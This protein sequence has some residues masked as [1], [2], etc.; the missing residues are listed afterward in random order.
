MN[1]INWENVQKFYDDSKDL[2]ATQK[3]FGI[4]TELIHNARKNGKLNITFQLEDQKKEKL[5]EM[6][7]EGLEISKIALKLGIYKFDVIQEC[8]KFNEKEIKL[9][10]K[11]LLEKT[12]VDWDFAQWLYDHNWR[13]EWISEELHIPVSQIETAGE[14]NIFKIT[15]NRIYKHSQF[16]K[17]KIA[18]ARK[19]FLNENPDKH[20]WKS[21]QKFKSQP[22][23]KIKGLLKDN[24]IDFLEEYQP[25]EEKNYSADIVLKDLGVIL[26]INGRQHYNYDGNLA[27]YYQHLFD[28]YSIILSQSKHFFF[29][30]TLLISSIATGLLSTSSIILSL[31]LISKA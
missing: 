21:H 28:L 6:Y 5:K 4:D 19:K 8:K 11:V 29:S 7:L 22:C 16:S 31:L 1:K 25:L 27:D 12:N 20:V 9:R 15:K 13:P 24:N 10:K 2:I 23:E 18:N 14:E 30:L 17:N 26:E 3:E